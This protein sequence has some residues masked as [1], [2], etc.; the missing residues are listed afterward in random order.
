MNT[1][2]KICELLNISYPIIQAPM[3]GGITTPELVASVANA[4]TLGSF[5]AGYLRPDEIRSSIKKIRMLTDKPFS[6][7]VFISEKHHATIDQINQACAEIE[8]ACQELS[9]HIDPI[10][11]PYASSLE[12]QMNVII[13]ENISVV[14]FTFGLLDSH[15]IKE[16]KNKN[17]RLIGTATNLDE[18]KLLERTGVDIIVAQ[19]M[20]AGGH[21]GTFL[22][23]VEK[24]LMSLNDLIFHLKEEIKIPIVAA[25]GIM[26]SGDI[27]SIMQF[28]ASGVQ[29][30]TAFLTCDESGADAIYKKTL[31]S[32]ARD[33]TV[34]TRAFSGKH[35]RGIDNKFIQ[36]MK[37]KNILDYPIQNALTNQMRKIAKENGNADFMSLWSGVGAKYCIETSTSELIKKLMVAF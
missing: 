27:K 24:S 13:E 7:N 8:N 12:E 26:N 15:W 25:G 10:L 28:G 37:D 17:V 18:A 22:G 4:G 14:S 9:I 33:Q 31:L 6:V 19:G 21:R 5:A 32:Q 1:K 23:A 34:L 16:L 36:R 20:E 30:G 11:P 2:N 29:I 35:A 3:A